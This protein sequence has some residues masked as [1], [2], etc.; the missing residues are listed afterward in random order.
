M[1]IELLNGF[2]GVQP[3]YKASQIPV[4]DSIETLKQQPVDEAKQQEQS[5]LYP[6]QDQQPVMDHRSRTADLENISLTFHKENDYSYLGSESSLTDLD[7]QKAISDMRKDSVL[8]EYQYF[9]GSAR[10]LFNG[11][12]DGA[13]VPKF[14]GIE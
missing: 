12:S 9:V 13:V 8:Q 5:V 2:G 6:S 7:V 1:G 14:T 11:S 4:Q 3:Y 10:T